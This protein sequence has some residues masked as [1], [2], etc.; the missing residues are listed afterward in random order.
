MASSGLYAR[1][2]HTFSS[3]ILFTKQSFSFAM[4]VRFAISDSIPA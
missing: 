2:C 1:L 3:F 4:L